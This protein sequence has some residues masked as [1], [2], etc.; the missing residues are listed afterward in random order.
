[1]ALGQGAFAIFGIETTVLVSLS[2]E[3][4][5]A[6]L[7]GIASLLVASFCWWLVP[8]TSFD[9]SLLF[10][11]AVATTIA[12][13]LAAV[14]GAILVRRAAQSFAPTKTLGRTAIAVTAAIALG[15]R[16]PWHGRPFVLVEVLLV[17]AAYL[18]V[19]IGTGELTRADVATIRT[20]LG[21]KR[22]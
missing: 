9:S 17:V 22:G 5:S 12:L 19:A 3:R 13:T 21:R 7:T 16:L 15:S 14:T 18:A 10:R 11:T 2:R 1:L 4:S 6:A 8:S 20:T